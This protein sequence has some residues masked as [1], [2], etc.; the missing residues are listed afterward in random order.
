MHTR[1]QKTGPREKAGPFMERCAYLEEPLPPSSAQTQQALV[2]GHTLLRSIRSRCH[3]VPRAA[4]EVVARC[5]IRCKLAWSRAA[6][7]C[8]GRE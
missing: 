5:C 7:A 2:I 4:R 3:M 6:V 1:K 8:A